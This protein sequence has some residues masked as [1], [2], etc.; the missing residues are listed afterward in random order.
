MR[1]QDQTLLLALLMSGL[2]ACPSADDDAGDD[3]GSDAGPAS[4][5][6]AEDESGSASSPADG[7]GGGSCAGLA[8]PAVCD[9]AGERWAECIYGGDPAIAESYALMCACFLNAAASDE[10]PECAAALEDYYACLSASQCM[11]VVLQEHCGAELLAIDEI[12]P[13]YSP[14]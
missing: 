3:D 1:A 4:S 6:A 9:G 12:C 7:S 13:P 2:P 8:A 14:A 11:P 5:T 10:G